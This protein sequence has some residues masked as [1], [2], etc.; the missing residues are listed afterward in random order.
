MPDKASRRVSRAYLV[1]ATSTT[2][3]AG[4]RLACVVG[5]GN[6]RHAMRLPDVHPALLFVLLSSTGACAAPAAPCPATATEHAEVEAPV[7]HYALPGLDHG[8][9]QS[10]VNI[11]SG[12]AVD[13]SHAI[14]LHVGDGAKQVT[15]KGHTVEV[16]FPS[17]TEFT[18]DG[19]TYGLLQIH[20]HTPSEHRIDG[21][22]YPMEVH[23]VSTCTSCPAEG[24]PRYL[25]SAVLYRMGRPSDFVARF[26]AAVPQSPGADRAL[27][28]DQVRVEQLLARS[29][30]A[31]T[32]YHYRGSLTTPPY[33]ETVEWLILKDIR[34][35]SPA[36]IAVI[37]QLE[38]DNARH[39]HALRGRV[40]DQ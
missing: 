17:G 19:N 10:P 33:T 29:L 9:V 15:N 13:K 26:L 37:N 25:V 16:E 22:T 7:E 5:F 39:I 28:E 6:N 3:S 34:T 24:P 27:P 2:G 14:E 30:Q 12:T 40:V 31:Q 8:L 11:L 23:V 35:A 21:I 32:F 38:G 36:Q 18:F 1:C 4:A 20:F